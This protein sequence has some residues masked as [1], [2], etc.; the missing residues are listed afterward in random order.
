MSTVSEISKCTLRYRRFRRPFDPRWRF[1]T[2]FSPPPRRILD[3]GCG[4]GWTLEQFAA[5]YPDAENYGVDI[6]D[7]GPGSVV[8][9][10]VD[11]DHEP[12]PFPN[13]HFDVVIMTHVVEHLHHPTFVAREIGRV[14]AP[15]GWLYIEAPNW[16]AAVTPWFSF[17]NDPTHVRPW[18]RNAFHSLLTT[19]AGLRI[20]AAG[21]RR[22]WPYVPRD[23][24]KLIFKAITG[25]IS[26][27][28]AEAHN[29][30]GWS[31]F[32][33]GQKAE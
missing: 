22:Q 3:I 19:Y 7:Q 4:P 2:G 20:E 33:I 13:S 31:V 23:L 17:W 9:H 12:L 11:L 29:V 32:S 14:L 18:S 21:N 24:V 30:L 27:A 5:I 26:N 1:M 28:R 16:T 6:L 10:R 15:G 8:Y 25:N